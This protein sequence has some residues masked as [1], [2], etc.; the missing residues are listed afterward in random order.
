QQSYGNAINGN[1][2]SV[3][4]LANPECVLAI[5]GQFARPPR[6]SA[7]G[8]SDA[9]WP[10]SNA[11]DRRGDRRAKS[12]RELSKGRRLQRRHWP[13]G[14]GISFIESRAV[15]SVQRLVEH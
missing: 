5:G 7:P 11:F 14:L 4:K 3:C 2:P 1:K 8:T 13:Q 10:V 12:H 15:Q 6:M 9:R